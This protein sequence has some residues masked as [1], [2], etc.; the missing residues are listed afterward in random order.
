MIEITQVL[1]NVYLEPFSIRPAH[2]EEVLH[3]ADIKQSLEFG[4]LEI[5]LYM[6]T[7]H[8]STPPTTL[9]VLERM[10]ENEKTVVDSAYKIFL[11]P[12]GLSFD[13]KPFEVL[14]ILAERFGI[15]LNVLGA[16]GKFIGK[17]TLTIPP[18]VDSNQIIQIKESCSFASS[19]YFRKIKDSLEIAFA[20]ALKTREYNH[21]LN[22]QK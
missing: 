17:K 13:T 21:W 11:S 8:N 12:L 7:S 15:T 4:E 10:L 20:F 1:R 22:S 14:K 2:I 9:I 16:E 19:F 18:G 6:R 3:N 5:N